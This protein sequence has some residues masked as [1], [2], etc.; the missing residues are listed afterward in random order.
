MDDAKNMTDRIKR[1]LKIDTALAPGRDHHIDALKGAA[2]I[3]VVLGHSIQVH[4]TRFDDN[5]LFRIIYSFHMPMLMFLS[6]VILS[7]QF[8][9]SLRH[10]MKKNA[11]RLV[12]PFL[13]WYLISYIVYGVFQDT[14]LLNYFLGLMKSPGR[15]LWFL[16]ILFLNSS[17]LF[18]VLKLVRH[19]KWQQW[20]NYFVIAAII[21]AR[22]ASEDVLGLSDFRQYFPYYAAGFLVCKYRHALKARRKTIYGAALILFPILVI[23]WRRNEFPAFYPVLVDILNNRGLPRL[24][25]SIYKYLVAFTGIAFISF[26]LE[27]AR[28]TNAYLFLCWLGTLTLDIYVC[29]GFFLKGFGTGWAAYFSAAVPGLICPLALTLLVMKRLRVT[30]LLLLGERH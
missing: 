29:H 5:L 20:E 15:G 1:F 8:G 14:G 16:W 24:M 30:R 28:Q 2:I 25:V 23:A 12:I 19:K 21:L 10:Y 9:Y 26:I 4:D 13:T 18:A 22:T 6:G 11:I 27:R 3:L 7:T 17:F